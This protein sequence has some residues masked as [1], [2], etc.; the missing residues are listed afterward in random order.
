MQLWLSAWCTCSW[1]NVCCRLWTILA[2][3]FLPPHHFRNRTLFP[4]PN[5]WLEIFSI[6]GRFSCDVFTFLLSVQKELQ[7]FSSFRLVGNAETVRC[8]LLLPF[9]IRLAILTP[10]RF[11]SLL[12][13]CVI[14]TSTVM[15]RTNL[16]LSYSCPTKQFNCSVILPLTNLPTVSLFRCSGFDSPLG[17]FCPFS[18]S[19]FSAFL[20]SVP[21]PFIYKNKTIS[22]C[23]RRF[24][25]R[26]ERIIH[27]KL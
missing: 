16:L 18:L 13:E 4:S 2:P 24:Q 3:L 22:T 7:H 8:P 10:N 12:S 5:V 14:D 25:K 23:V 11:H 6:S 1:E 20:S 26:K 15:S 27:N 9:F 17:L 21:P 19:V